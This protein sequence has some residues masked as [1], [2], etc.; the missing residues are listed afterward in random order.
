MVKIGKLTASI[1]ALLI[2]ISTV[3]YAQK[4]NIQLSVNVKPIEVG[5]MVAFTVKSNV[6]G[7][8]SINL[9]TSFTEAGVM[10]GMEQTMDGS[11][12]MIISISYTQQG[13]FS[14]PGKY[15]ITA[16]V[17]DKSKTY[18]S[19]DLAIV[20]RKKGDPKSKKNYEQSEEDISNS[21]LKEAVFG[22]IQ[23]SKRKMYEGEPLILEA[24]IYSKINVTNIVQ[25]QPFT[26]KGTVES[27]DIEKTD[28]VSINRENSKGTAFLT[29]S[30]GKQLVFPATS[31]KYII[32][33]FAMVLRYNNGGFFDRDLQFESNATYVDVLPLPKGAPKDFNGGVG[34][35]SFASSLSK[36]N[37]KVGDILTYVVK[38]SGKGNMHAISK[39][40]LNLPPNLAVY[41]DPEIKDDID[42]T[43]D[44]VE[45]DKTYTFFLKVVSGGKIE[46]NPI[47]LSYFDPALKKYVTIK[48][49]SISL[50]LEGEITNSKVEITDTIVANNEEE[51]VLAVP[52]TD[53]KIAAKEAVPYSKIWITLLAGLVILLG[54]IIYF[55]VRKRK[56]EATISPRNESDLM[57]KEPLQS[58]KEDP[59]LTIEFAQ[60]L[61]SQGDFKR[62]FGTIHKI[63][64]K[65]IQQRF[66]VANELTSQEELQIKM[67]QAGCSEGLISDYFWVIRTC[68]E[69]EYAI[70]DTRDKWDEVLVKSKELIRYFA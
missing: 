62:A 26:I 55:L 58:T 43:E 39:P 53:E 41:G 9:P 33:P 5:Q 57:E 8:I 25:Y 47:S 4:P 37:A 13:V 35:F 59:Y 19:N 29:F 31:G 46:M 44:G 3:V 17:K 50:D 7:N 34:K 20:V 66:N 30:Y 40:K 36:T 1:V 21:N 69:A 60:S 64:T 70:W 11:G 32:K 10:N 65:S 49:K 2:S 18:K 23:K 14:K 51:E 15:T 38:V 63:I 67:Q 68:Q 54:G 52:L 56:N 28:N 42:Y 48:E 22:I 45:G 61:A 6:N 16:S 24:K 12:N 27:F